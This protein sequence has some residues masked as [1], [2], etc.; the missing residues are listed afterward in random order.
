MRAIA[1]I[2]AR[3][4]SLRI[5]GKNKRMFH[6][7]PIICYSI[8]AAQRSG[9]FEGVIV[10]TDD[11]DIANIAHKAGAAIH[12]RPAVLCSD[13]VGTQVVVQHLASKLYAE[14][15]FRRVC[16][17]YATAPLMDWR[18]IG[19]AHS[20]IDDNHDFAMTVCDD[21]LSDAAQV[22]WSR[23]HYIMGKPLIGSRT[24]MIPVDKRRVC[25][26]NTEEDW[27]RAERMYAELMGQSA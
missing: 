10:S 16:C 5:P 17:I 9:L 8:E 4:G 14:T 24:A 6:G 26:I 1:I 21:P 15:P 23:T 11:D 25:D 18:D 3:G 2:P 27:M 22:Y 13:D 12:M 20:E 7:K 19:R